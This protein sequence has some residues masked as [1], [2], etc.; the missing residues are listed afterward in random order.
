MVADAVDVNQRIEETICEEKKIIKIRMWKKK[1]KIFQL[2]GQTTISL[3]EW[4]KKLTQ[5]FQ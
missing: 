1:E 5:Q 2:K 4:I 3:I